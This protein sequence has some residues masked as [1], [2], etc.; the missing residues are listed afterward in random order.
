MLTIPA[1][2]GGTQMGRFTGLAGQPAW[3]SIWQAPVSLRNTVSGTT[4]D[5]F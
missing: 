1:L 4:V 2:G 5:S 3:L